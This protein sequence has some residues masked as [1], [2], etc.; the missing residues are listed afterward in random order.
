MNSFDWCAYALNVKGSSKVCDLFSNEEFIRQSYYNDIDNYY[1]N[2]PG[3]QMNLDVGSVYLNSSLRLLQDESA[4]NK[5]WLSFSHDTD[6]EIFLAA[7]GIIAPQTDLP[8]D[9][10]NSLI[11]INMHK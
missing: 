7:L 9:Q 6:L 11:N 1:S 10:F 3:N 2:G 8:T 5:I 4:N